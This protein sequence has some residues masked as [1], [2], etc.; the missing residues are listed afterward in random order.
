MGEQ[1]VS[2]DFWRGGLRPD[3]LA[4]FRKRRRRVENCR[5]AGAKKERPGGRSFVSS[6]EK[7]YLRILRR[8]T[9]AKAPRPKRLIVAGSG[10]AWTEKS[11]E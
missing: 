11:A 7:D 6:L 9:I 2:M 1:A 8:R 4:G 10:T 5:E 3:R